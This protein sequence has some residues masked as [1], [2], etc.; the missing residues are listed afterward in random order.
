M[1]IAVAALPF[2]TVNTYREGITNRV[3]P[4]DTINPKIMPL[5]IGAHSAPPNSDSGNRPPMVV[6][7]VSTIGR[8]RK[9]PA[10]TTAS[11]SGMPSATA[12]SP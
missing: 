4:V 11:R 9:R 12:R 3:S 7:L 2:S 8:T 10:L 1:L 5:V 6:R